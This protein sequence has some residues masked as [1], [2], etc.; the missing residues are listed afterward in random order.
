VSADCQKALAMLAAGMS[1]DAC[2]DFS[3]V[4]RIALCKGWADFESRTAPT[5]SEAVRGAW[6]DIDAACASHGGTTPEYGELAAIEHREGP[7]SALVRSIEAREA[8]LRNNED[9]SVCAQVL[10]AHC[11]MH[12]AQDA[13]YCDLWERYW[14]DRGLTSDDVLYELVRLETPQQREEVAQDL[15]AR[16]AL[17]TEGAT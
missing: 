4:R 11:A 15:A 17:Q 2:H 7:D 10:Q 3:E 6:R 14:T 13:R 9:C 16:G 12:G 8:D 5:F 1:Y